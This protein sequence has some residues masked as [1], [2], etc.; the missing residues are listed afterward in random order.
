MQLSRSVLQ[1]SKRL[2]A[3]APAAQHLWVGSPIR[4]LRMNLNEGHLEENMP[5]TSTPHQQED[6]ARMTIHFGVMEGSNCGQEA[7]WRDRS[8][9]AP[10]FLLACDKEIHPEYCPDEMVG[11]LVRGAGDAP[12]A[13]VAFN[14]GLHAFYV[15]LNPLDAALRTAMERQRSAGFLQVTI[16][17]PGGRTICSRNLV[18][19]HAVSLADT[20]GHDDVASEK[21]MKAAEALAPMLPAFAHRRRKK[22][23]EATSHHVYLMLTDSPDHR[24]RAGLTSPA[25]SLAT[26]H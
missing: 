2:R 15:L 21:W 22:I 18:A 13:Y 8:E 5:K 3:R 11:G 9:R 1:A 20:E 10:A 17:L 25:G 26:M 19:A 7:S 16:A 24:M 4:I 12:V 23:A 6:D 14:V